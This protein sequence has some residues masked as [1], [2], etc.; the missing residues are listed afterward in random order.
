MELCC[1]CVMTNMKVD[2]REIF[3]FRCSSGE[4]IHIWSECGNISVSNASHHYI[5]VVFYW[6]KCNLCASFK[7]WRNYI[8]YRV[9]VSCL[10]KYCCHSN[11]QYVSL[12]STCTYSCTSYCSLLVVFYDFLFHVWNLIV[13][14]IH[15]SWR[16]AGREFDTAAR[17]CWPH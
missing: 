8:G 2:E 4:H 5:I 13:S 12:F 6:Y 16:D 11:H 14:F 17:E 1:D 10:V 7:L 3:W 9:L 15:E